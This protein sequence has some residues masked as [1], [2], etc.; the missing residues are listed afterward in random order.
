MTLLYVYAA[1]GLLTGT[2][3][4]VNAFMGAYEVEGREDAFWPAC[5]A[6]IQFAGSAALWPIAW[7]FFLFAEPDDGSGCDLDED[8]EE[9]E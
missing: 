2:W 6:A 3:V 9:D 8:G 4:A 7:A 1:I 5:Y